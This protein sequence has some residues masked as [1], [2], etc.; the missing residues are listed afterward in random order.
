[1]KTVHIIKH[2]PSGEIV[3]VCSNKE[4]VK[5]L[6]VADIRGFKDPSNVITE[7]VNVAFCGNNN[8][9]AVATYLGSL[10][11]YYDIIEANLF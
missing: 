8:E 6:I 4:D 1:M 9:Y 5:R 10:P 7:G 2:N 3:A 11:E